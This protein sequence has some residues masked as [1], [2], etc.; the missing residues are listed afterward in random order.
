[1]SWVYLDL[2]PSSRLILRGVCGRKR[3][4]RDELTGSSFVH[5][6][7]CLSRHLMGSSAASEAGGEP[8]MD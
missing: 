1:M 2:W 3:L 8:H 6:C 4:T 7:V 5:P